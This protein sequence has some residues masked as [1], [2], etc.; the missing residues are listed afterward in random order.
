ML[1]VHLCKTSN[2]VNWRVKINHNQRSLKEQS[3]QSKQKASW[4]VLSFLSV[5]SHGS[6]IVTADTNAYGS[7]IKSATRA[8]SGSYYQPKSYLNTQALWN[9]WVKF[10]F[11]IQ[12]IKRYRVSVIVLSSEETQQFADALGWQ[13]WNNSLLHWRMITS[14][15]NKLIG[16]DVLKNANFCFIDMQNNLTT[17]PYKHLWQ[18]IPSLGV[19]TPPYFSNTWIGITSTRQH[20][21]LQYF[22]LTCVL[23]HLK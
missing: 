21:S 23:K 19:N 10:C 18:E 15:K 7:L 2:N 17:S 4:L 22:L 8:P 14:T 9:Q 6:H 5:L 12:N 16:K 13:S 20:P 11:L 1:Y 3:K